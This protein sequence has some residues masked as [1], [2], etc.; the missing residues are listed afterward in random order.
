MNCPKSQGLEKEFKFLL[1]PTQYQALW[2][3]LRA[4]STLRLQE[5]TFFDRDEMLRRA[6]WALRLR[7]EREPRISL[8]DQNFESPPPM[9]HLDWSAHQ[10]FVTF[11]GPVLSSNQGVVRPEVEEEIDLVT[12]EQVRQSGCVAFNRLPPSV[13]GALR[14]QVADN[15]YHGWLFQFTTFINLRLSRKTTVANRVIEVA[16]DQSRRGDGQTRYELEV[17]YSGDDDQALQAILEEL[18]TKRYK[19]T[20]SGKLTWVMSP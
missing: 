7:I 6:R 4:R 13:A 14:A 12:A 3:R 16:L 2:S 9:G 20:T 10:A 1:E 11:K 19:P 18:D 8:S 5:N 17:E 15:Q